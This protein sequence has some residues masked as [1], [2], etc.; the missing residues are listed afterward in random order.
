M[1][2]ARSAS[3]VG[4]LLMV[5][6]GVAVLAAISFVAMYCFSIWEHEWYFASYKH[7]MKFVGTKGK[8]GRIEYFSVRI[9]GN[10]AQ[11]ISAE[12]ELEFHWK[13]QKYLV[14]ELG[15]DDLAEMGVS[16]KSNTYTPSDVMTGFLG[17]KDDRNQ[18]YG[19]EFYFRSGRIYHFY[20]R[21]SAHNNVACPFMLSLS[22]RPPVSF[23]IGEEQLQKSFGVPDSVVAVPGH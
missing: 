10:N 7:E 1:K 13:G 11:A 12:C 6:V 2:R 19:V 3:R 15:L 4:I 16:A 18:D 5:A 21:Y 8:D 20:A 14:R 17:G 9:G 22:Q 23:P